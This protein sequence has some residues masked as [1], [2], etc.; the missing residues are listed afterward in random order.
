MIYYP[1]SILMLAGVRD[2]V[3]VTQKKNF[4]VI[5]KEF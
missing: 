4:A 2:F 5:I 3:I 1:M